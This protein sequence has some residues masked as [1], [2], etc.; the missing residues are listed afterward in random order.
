MMNS[1]LRAAAVSSPI[2]SG[3]LV[4]VDLSSAEAKDFPFVSGVLQIP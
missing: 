4:L 1:I 3:S 2:H